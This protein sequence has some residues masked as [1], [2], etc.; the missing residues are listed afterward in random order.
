[1]SLRP[2][3]VEMGAKGKLAI[4]GSLLTGHITSHKYLSVSLTSLCAEI[5]F[6]FIKVFAFFLRNCDTRATVYQY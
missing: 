1:M 4:A 3:G 5:K 2:H 6:R